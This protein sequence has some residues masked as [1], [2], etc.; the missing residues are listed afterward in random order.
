MIISCH[1]FPFKAQFTQ[2]FALTNQENSINGTHQ[3]LGEQVPAFIGGEI[4][5]IGDDNEQQWATQHV[6]IIHQNPSESS[7]TNVELP[8]HPDKNVS[9]LSWDVQN[10]DAGLTSIPLVITSQN[11]ITQEVCI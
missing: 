3:L 10:H 8:Q 6:T 9:H 5:R 1:L 11:N 7:V 4:H 2:V